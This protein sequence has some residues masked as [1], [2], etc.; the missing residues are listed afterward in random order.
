MNPNENPFFRE[1]ELLPDKDIIL[2]LKYQHDYDPLAVEA[3]QYQFEKRNLTSTDI[4]NVSVIETA[5]KTHQD[6]SRR[7]KAKTQHIFSF[8]ASFTEKWSRLKN[9]DRTA[10]LIILLFAIIYSLFYLIICIRN[11]NMMKYEINDFDLGEFLLL[12]TQFFLI[13]LGYGLFIL[14]R[15]IGWMIMTLNYS[16][17]ITSVLL[18]FL[19][20]WAGPHLDNLNYEG[21][22]IKN[23]TVFFVLLFL[24]NGAMIFMLLFHRVRN[25]F[26][27][28]S[29]TAFA[30]AMAG[31]LITFV[32]WVDN[33]NDSLG[34]KTFL[35]LLGIIIFYLIVFILITKR[36][37]QPTPQ[38]G[39]SLD[40]NIFEAETG[41]ETELPQPVV[42]MD[43]PVWFEKLYASIKKEHK[44]LIRSSEERLIILE[45]LK[46]KC[47]DRDSTQ[48]VL[49]TYH[50]RYDRNLIADLSKL[51]SSFAAIKENIE[52][53][54]RFDL[55]A[56]DYPHAIT[57]S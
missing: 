13:T 1:Y 45:L 31:S 14:L 2:T 15:R 9:E 26:K 33:L 6:F 35:V 23:P 36:L 30:V 51:S 41:R 38:V 10:H 12:H 57:E 40:H 39:I 25:V 42:K 22:T 55:V 24:L 47:I 7:L 17:N 46:E 50:D 56:A 18:V 27:V 52:P 43:D 3:A 37:K 44:R 4:E 32:V 48:S 19:M 28:R 29:V 21:I 5:L 34:E 49:Q 8:S 16:L 20:F 53:F 11:I 54:I